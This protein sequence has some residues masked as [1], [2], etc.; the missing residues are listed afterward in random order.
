[1]PLLSPD[2][3][4]YLCLFLKHLRLPHP[5]WPDPSDLP[6]AHMGFLNFFQALR[7]VE[8]G[9]GISCAYSFLPL[10]YQSL[11]SYRS[12]DLRVS[13]FLSPLSF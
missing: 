12:R 7:G 13:G 10:G 8:W 5:P 2:L 4:R 11:F 9:A 6:P 1:M 3:A